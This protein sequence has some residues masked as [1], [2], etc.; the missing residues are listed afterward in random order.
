[1]ARPRSTGG[2]AQGMGK[3]GDSMLQTM[4]AQ[5]MQ[6]QSTPADAPPLAVEPVAPNSAINP[7][8]LIKALKDANF[9]VG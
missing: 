7:D 6:G 9:N 8:E 1:M 5:L 3:F 2:F 4:M